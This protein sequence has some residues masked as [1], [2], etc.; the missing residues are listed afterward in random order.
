LFALPAGSF[1][2]PFSGRT[3][4]PSSSP[5]PMRQ[6]VDQVIEEVTRVD[7]RISLNFLSV[8][9]DQGYNE[10]FEP[11][12]NQ[13]LGFIEEGKFGIEFRDFVLSI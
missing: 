5:Q 2:S 1:G 9:G 13:V 6:R 7:S 8:D 3:L 12:F 10:Y 11:E 4:A